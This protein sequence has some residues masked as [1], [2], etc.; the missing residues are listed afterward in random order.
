MFNE[1]KN[2][3]AMVLPL[4]PWP[5]YFGNL[6]CL[7]CKINSRKVKRD[8]IS[9]ITDFVHNFLQELPN[10]LRLNFRKLENIKKNFET[11]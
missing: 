9:G 4:Q 3:V 1:Y 11:G 7:Q 10:D 5:R 6:L 2:G 8:L